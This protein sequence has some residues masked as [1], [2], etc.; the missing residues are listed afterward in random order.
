[1]SR[2]EFAAKMREELG[3]AGTTDVFSREFTR[4]NAKQKNGIHDSHF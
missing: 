1:V 2:K 3:Q 4:M